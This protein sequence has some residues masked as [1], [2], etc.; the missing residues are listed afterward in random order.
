MALSAF[1]CITGLECLG[2]V[3]AL[4]A[5]LAS[6]HVC[7]GV[8]ATLLHRED[9]CVAVIALQALVCMSLAIKHDLSRASS[10]IFDGLSR[11]YCESA[12]HKCNN[13]EQSNKQCCLLHI[14]T[15]FHSGIL[16][17]E[18]NTYLGLPIII[19]KTTGSG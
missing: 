4:A 18:K 16:L 11:R 8:L 10:C 2:A 19:A 5:I 17:P 13:N 6:V 12:A 1:S 3:M 9:L 15:P 7:H 14:F